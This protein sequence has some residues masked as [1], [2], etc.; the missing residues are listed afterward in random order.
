MT[1]FLVELA[2]STGLLAPLAA[3][4]SPRPVRIAYTPE[5]EAVEALDESIR[6]V[7]RERDFGV[8]YGNSSGYGSDRHYVSEWMPQRFR[9]I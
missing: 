4:K 7:H 6:H 3:P 5:A 1:R 9:S 2:S 8:G